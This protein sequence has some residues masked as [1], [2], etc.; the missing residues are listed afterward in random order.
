MPPYVWSTRHSLL[1]WN[2]LVVPSGCFV[3]GWLQIGY[4]VTHIKWKGT[5]TLIAWNDE[6]LTGNAI[7]DDDHKQLVEL[8]N[9]ICVASTAKKRT[10][11]QNDLVERMLVLT[12][13]HFANE[14]RLM[15]EYRYEMAVHH[16]SEHQ[17]MWPLSRI[18][19]LT[20]IS[21]ARIG[22]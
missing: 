14:Q 1:Y 12:R 20:L 3:A 19:L 9:A 6:L 5:S 22:A 17:K 10:V 18:W 21:I 15:L 11:F 13:R 7:I 2:A 8:I 16:A 4:A